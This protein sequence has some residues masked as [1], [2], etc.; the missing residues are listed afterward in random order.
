ML[1]QFNKHNNN[2][3]NKKTWVEPVIDISNKD[4]IRVFLFLILGTFYIG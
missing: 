1:N 2:N 4:K 3:N